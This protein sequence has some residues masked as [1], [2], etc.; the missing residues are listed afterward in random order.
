MKNNTNVKNAIMTGAMIASKLDSTHSNS[1]DTTDVKNA[2]M[3]GAMIASKLDS[4]PSNR[5]DDLKNAIQSKTSEIANKFSEIFK[6]SSN[7]FSEIF[8]DPNQLVRSEVITTGIFKEG[9]KEFV[10]ILN[11]IINT[12]SDNT[13]INHVEAKTTSVMQN[14]T[15]G[16]ANTDM[17]YEKQLAVINELIQIVNEETE[18]VNT[19]IEM[20]TKI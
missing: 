6:G 1:Y 10:K 19:K 18:K 8:N 14:I 17:S 5:F 16:I 20:Y 15:K 11:S 13:S 2:I 9:N 7:M 3:T 12:D 4:T